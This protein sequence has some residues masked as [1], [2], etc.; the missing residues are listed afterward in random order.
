M[1]VLLVTYDLNKPGKDYTDVL[2]EIRKFSWAKL[3]ESS[4]A[5][6]TDLSPQQLYNRLSPYLDATDTLYVIELHLP[7]HGQG[8]KEV[9]DWLAKRLTGCRVPAY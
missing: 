4:Y 3:S 1:S 8:P 2:K 6:E 9:N 7:Y 5:V